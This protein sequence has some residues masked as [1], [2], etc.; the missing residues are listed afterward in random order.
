MATAKSRTFMSTSAR[1]PRSWPSAT[2][3]MP[4]TTND[5]RFKLL[6]RPAPVL[7]ELTGNAADP[8]VNPGGSIPRTIR[9]DA[10]GRV[11]VRIPRNAS[12]GRGYVIYGVSGPQG[13]LS[14]VDTSRTLPGA[15]PTAANNGTA[16]LSDIDVVTGDSFTVRMNTTPVTLPPPAGESEPVRDVN[17]DGDTAMLKL[18]EGIDLNGNGAVDEVKPGTVTYGFENFKTTRTPGYVSSGKENIGTGTGI[19]EQVID[20]TH[21]SEGRH[22]LTVRVFRHRDAATGGDGGPPVFTD[23]R[24]TIYID[25]STPA[26]A[27]V[28]RNSSENGST[29]QR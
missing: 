4:A 1:T 6:S 3:S 5:L 27:A 19:Y 28:G 2:A 10:D 16:R 11:A 8:V 24:R 7:V 26:T 14:L 15:A 22:Y 25:R 23:F 9:V 18:D 17:A 13:S 20:T 12:H 29:D 21:L